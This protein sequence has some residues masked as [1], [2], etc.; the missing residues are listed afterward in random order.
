MFVWRLF[1][2][3]A[4]ATV[5]LVA[6]IGIGLLVAPASGSESRA[7]LAALLERDAPAILRNLGDAFDAARST[8]GDVLK[9][10]DRSSP[11]D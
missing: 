11:E 7:R 3:T 4:T 2:A 1:T 8:A 10:V 5:A 6:G 9:R